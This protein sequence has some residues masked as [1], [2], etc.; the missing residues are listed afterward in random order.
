MCGPIHDWHTLVLSSGFR[1]VLYIVFLDWAYPWGTLWN[2]F[3]GDHISVWLASWLK[4]FPSI[5]CMNLVI[6]P[7]LWN[8]FLHSII[9][10]GT[11]KCLFR[12]SSFLQDNYNSIQ[13]R[14]EIFSYFR[15]WNVEEH[16]EVS[17]QSV[18]FSKSIV[19]SV[20]LPLLS[21]LW[22]EVYRDTWV[23]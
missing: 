18:R 16:L 19:L 7:I 8:H 9:S 22:P 13:P 1:S 12:I 4:H 3:L 5:A 6:V 15:S 17:R 10:E 21:S 2:F 11:N 23:V 14:R 20:W